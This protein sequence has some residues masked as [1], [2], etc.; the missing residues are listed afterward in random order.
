MAVP[1]TRRAFTLIELLVVIA[2][3]AILIGL[4]LP[5]VQK[6]REAANRTKCSNNLKQLGLAT[7]NYEFNKKS[8]PGG[9]Y[10]GTGYFGPQAIV[11]PYVE[12]G[13]VY[14]HIQ[15]GL[16]PYDTTVNPKDSPWTNYKVG[17]LRPPLIVCPSEIYLNPPTPT[18]AMG[19]G[20]YHANSGTW[21]STAKKWDGVFGEATSETANTGT[22]ITIPPLK[23]VRIADIKDGTT[24]TVM[25]SEVSNGPSPRD[26]EPKR[27]I[28]CY[29]AG[30]VTT[31]S[32]SAAQTAL[33]AKNWQ[34]A[35]LI[36]WDSGGPWR[37][38]GYPW[39]EGSIFKGWYNHLLPPNNPCWRA[40]SDWWQLVTPA[41]SYHMGGV[42]IVMC[43]GSVRFI[44]D[45]IDPAV[46]LAAGTR[47]GGETAQLPQ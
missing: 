8:F 45:D 4:L 18:D 1:Q 20:N 35:S 38:R 33:L 7:L 6:V 41:S 17:A 47:A 39:T 24:N 5:A 22:T 44:A 40:N 16:G 15:L 32:A 29:E 13:A 28:D 26:S 34:T 12:Q 30:T 42:N 3:I 43:D 25:Y 46:W 11:L 14:D 23:P 27:K 9:A 19:W 37:Y 31:T 2:I 36:A 21:V 10:S